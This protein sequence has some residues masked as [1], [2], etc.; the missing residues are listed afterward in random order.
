[1]ID[2]TSIR[3]ISNVDI[4]FLKNDEISACYI[5]FPLMLEGHC[6]K[7]PTKKVVFMSKS[8]K[9]SH[10][11]VQQEFEATDL[12]KKLEAGEEFSQLAKDFS[13]CPSGKEGGDLGFFSKGQMVKPFEDAAFGLDIGGVSGPVRTQFGYHL[14]K[15][16]A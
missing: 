4:K 16:E 11:L 2:E 13:L 8:I 5:S 3:V 15:R 10:I 9:A 12:I 1:M 6:V 7:M 14:I